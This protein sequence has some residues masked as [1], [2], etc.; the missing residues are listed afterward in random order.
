VLVAGIAVY[1]YFLIRKR[2]RTNC[3]KAFLGNNWLGFA[4]FSGLATQYSIQYLR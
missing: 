2:E 4:V 1:H 3:F